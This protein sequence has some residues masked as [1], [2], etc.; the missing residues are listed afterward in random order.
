MNAR[1]LFVVAAMLALVGPTACHRSEEHD[2]VE[3]L[4]AKP[5]PAIVGTGVMR[6]AAFRLADQHGKV[7]VVSFGYTSCLEVCPD[8]FAKMK[9]V[10]DDLA[11]DVGE[12]AFD[13][14]T[15][16][17]DRDTPEHFRKFL[18]GVDTRFEGIYIPEAELPATLARWDVVRRKRLPDPARYAARDVDASAFY[19]MDHTAGFW[20]VDR[21]GRLRARYPHDTPSQGV[22]DAVRLLL[23]ER[24][25]S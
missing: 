13:Y 4:D 25:Q 9:R 1:W 21:R 15:V 19:S 7:V 2:G 23:G 11:S 3:W 18:T 8:T 24:G 20:L 22:L 16:D 17:P 12:V 5:A 6:G 10:F 14:V